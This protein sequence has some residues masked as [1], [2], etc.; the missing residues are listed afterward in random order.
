MYFLRD[1]RDF[2][3]IGMT[4]RDVQ[5][6]LQEIQLGASSL[7]KVDLEIPGGRDVEWAVHDIFRRFRVRGEWF[8][9][10]PLDGALKRAEPGTWDR[11]LEWG[12]HGYHVAETSNLDEYEILRAA[13]MGACGGRPCAPHLLFDH[14]SSWSRGGG[15]VHVFQPYI[16]RFRD[17]GLAKAAAT[18]KRAGMDVFISHALSWWNPCTDGELSGSTVLTAYARPGV[19]HDFLVGV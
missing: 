9:N 8:R 19:L 3:K 18:A 16:G 10:L 13:G 1:E 12:R 14:A 6:R 11:F 7:L 5:A 2:V 17:G 15:D 4:E